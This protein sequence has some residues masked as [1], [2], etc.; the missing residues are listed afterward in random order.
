MSRPTTFGNNAGLRT[1]LGFGADPV[2]RFRT[3]VNDVDYGRRL[4]GEVGHIPI[5]EKQTLKRTGWLPAQQGFV[6]AAQLTNL[7]NAKVGLATAIP[8]TK[9]NP[10]VIPLTPMQQQLAQLVSSSR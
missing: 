2:G 6:G 8:A 7:V 1:I 4:D 10:G 3:S 9:P 5:G